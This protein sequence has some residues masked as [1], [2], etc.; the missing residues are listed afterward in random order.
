MKTQKI[1]SFEKHG[2]HRKVY[3]W[4]AEL[5]NPTAEIKLSVEHRNYKWVPIKEAYETLHGEETKKIFI[6][7]HTLISEGKLK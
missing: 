6:H 5:R 7:Y 3:C 4:L 1:L 2:I